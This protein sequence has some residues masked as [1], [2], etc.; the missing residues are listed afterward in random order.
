MKPTIGRIVLVS[1][2]Q[3]P[4]FGSAEAPAIVH[5]IG[6]DGGIGLTVFLLNGID[7]FAASAEEGVESPTGL[8]WRWPPRA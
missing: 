5:H 6:E 7:R 8:K 4:D 2:P 3:H 1:H